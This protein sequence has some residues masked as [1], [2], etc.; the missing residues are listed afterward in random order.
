MVIR[1]Y[2]QLKM[3]FRGNIKTSQITYLEGFPDVVNI[4][5]L[6]LVDGIPPA[7]GMQV[8]HDQHLE[9]GDKCTAWNL[10]DQESS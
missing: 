1:L 2:S 3:C 6:F 4:E 5:P 7:L 8:L 10:A 9:K